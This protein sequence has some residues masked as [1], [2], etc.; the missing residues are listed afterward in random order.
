M[1]CQSLF[2]VSNV[3]LVVSNIAPQ[4]VSFNR[5][6]WKQFERFT[7]DLVKDFEAVV[8]YTGPIF[9]PKLEDDGK[10]YV[11]YEMI[12]NPANTPV[13]THFYKVIVGILDQKPYSAAFVIP[14]E[15]IQPHT[16]LQSFLV[17]IESVERA[18]GVIFFPSLLI[19]SQPLCSKVKCA[20]E[21][22][23][24]ARVKIQNEK[25]QI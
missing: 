20:V 13:P 3:S 21:S 14:N 22:F 9:L 7:K 15:T 5:G 1:H 18:T 24:L 11:K 17:P 4:V 19:P 23:R 10:F 8:V 12:G 6:Y 25:T 16:P 2:T